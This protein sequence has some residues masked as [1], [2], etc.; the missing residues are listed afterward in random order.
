MNGTEAF[1]W[2]LTETYSLAQIPK[3]KLQSYMC[4]SQIIIWS[5]GLHIPQIFSSLITIC[6]MTVGPG[7]DDVCP[8]G[9]IHH[10]DITRLHFNHS[11][12]TNNLI[13]TVKTQNIIESLT[14]NLNLPLKEVSWV[15]RIIIRWNPIFQNWRLSR[16][17]QSS[18]WEDKS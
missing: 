8:G 10:G 9:G 3:Y 2:I 7:P 17:L 16:N 14:S 18:G 13:I 11:N 4:Q 15:G 6:I 1:V 5:L 12:Q